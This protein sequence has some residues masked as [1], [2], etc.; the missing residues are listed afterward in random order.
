MEGQP[1]IQADR[2]GPRRVFRPEAVEHYVTR[3]VEAVFP[4]LV[5]PR[6]FSSLWL[7]AGLLFVAL[8]VLGVLV[9]GRTGTAEA[10]AW[11]RRVGLG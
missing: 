11:L 10:A 2:P 1:G 9:D 7:V 6:A 3:R 4:R 8:L 5:A